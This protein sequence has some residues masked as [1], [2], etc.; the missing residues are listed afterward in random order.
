MNIHKEVILWMASFLYNEEMKKKHTLRNFILAVL[1]LNIAYWAGINM[2]VS[3]VLVP[4]FMERLHA[5]D[6]I[7]EQ[8]YAEQV[9]E[10]SL[11]N[12]AVSMN[13][14][15]MSWARNNGPEERGLDPL[16]GRVPA[17]RRSV[18]R[19]SPGAGFRPQLGHTPARLHRQQGDDVRICILVPAKG[20]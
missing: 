15:G 12:N 6:R 17:A 4:S 9:Q 18:C 7:V 14:I 10:T 5:F 20:I 13:V 11:Q 16:E 19:G 1:I 2:L 8:S 3:A